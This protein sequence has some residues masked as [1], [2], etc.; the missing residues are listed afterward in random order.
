MRPP[1]A[2][3]LSSYIR[4]CRTPMGEA[5]DTDDKGVDRPRTACRGPVVF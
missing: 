5:S 2:L 4:V 3:D 1:R